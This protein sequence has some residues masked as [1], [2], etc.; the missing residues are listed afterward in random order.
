MQKFCGNDA[1]YSAMKTS[2][3]GDSV[4]NP[5]P[6]R[7]QRIC[8]LW[9]DGRLV[10]TLTLVSCLMPAEARA[11]MPAKPSPLV[12]DDTRTALASANIAAVAIGGVRL[13]DPID[14]LN[15]IAVGSYSDLVPLPVA[16]T[17]QQNTAW[18]ALLVQLD[19]LSEGKLN[20]PDE[21]D[22]RCPFG[23]GYVIILKAKE[24]ANPPKWVRLLVC[25]DCNLVEAASFSSANDWF[26]K[27]VPPAQPPTL[28][29]LAT[30]I[31][32]HNPADTA[33]RKEHLFSYAP[34]IKES[35]KP[36]DIAAA[37]AQENA[38]ED[39]VRKLVEVLKIKR[40]D[41]K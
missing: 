26:R 4:L 35:S 19:A 6:T 14:A 41:S 5:Q 2:L 11:Q 12:F 31:G 21:K 28:A 32:D 3:R 16:D 22:I 25:F 30:W 33:N 37:R 29:E 17:I 10:A 20:N 40:P 15:K 9:S 38:F 18:K 1:P 27:S 23:P 7:I 13:A 24:Q 39:A 8:R 36:D 34:P